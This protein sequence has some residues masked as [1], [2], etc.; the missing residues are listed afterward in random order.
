[1]LERYTGDP[2]IEPV[3][4]MEEITYNPR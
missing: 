4:T 1:V 2:S 3:T